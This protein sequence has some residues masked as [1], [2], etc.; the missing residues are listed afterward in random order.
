[1][2]IFSV[3]RIFSGVPGMRRPIPIPSDDNYYYIL[4]R[5]LY[6]WQHAYENCLKLNGTL[7]SIDSNEI[8]VQLLLVMGENKDEREW[9]QI[10]FYAI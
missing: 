1:M 3:V 4:V 8:L 9:F 6:Y 5:Q 2:F 7:A 10:H